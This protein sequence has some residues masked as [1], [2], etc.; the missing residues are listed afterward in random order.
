M[1]FI[2]NTYQYVNAPIYGH[3]FVTPLKCVVKQDCKGQ[4]KK[5]VLEIGGFN[6]YKKLKKLN[7]DDTVQIDAK[8]KNPRYRRKLE[9]QTMTYKQMRMRDMPMICCKFIKIRQ[10]GSKV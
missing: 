10:V 4:L 6:R 5:Q 1:S 7:G 9:A 2:N 3:I 8:K